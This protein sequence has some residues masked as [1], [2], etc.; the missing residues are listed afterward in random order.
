MTVT[1]EPD[2]V[3]FA[4]FAGIDSNVVSSDDFLITMFFA[5]TAVTFSEKFSTMFALT[6]T[7]VALSAGVDDESVG[8]VT[9]P[10]TDDS[11]ARP[12]SHP[13]EAFTVVFPVPSRLNLT[14]LPFSRT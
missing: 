14:T 3:T 11:I 4:S 9:S 6:P 8:A 12:R 7:P 13:V 1:V 10:K 2:T 5:A